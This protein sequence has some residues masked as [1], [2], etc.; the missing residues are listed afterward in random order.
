VEDPAGIFASDLDARL[1]A[2]ALHG[3]AAGP[4]RRRLQW[5][6]EYRQLAARVDTALLENDTLGPADPGHE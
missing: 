5:E 1:F 3:R 2:H 6:R 4:I